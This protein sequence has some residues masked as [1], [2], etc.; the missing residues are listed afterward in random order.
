MPYQLGGGI[1]PSIVAPGSPGAI[2]HGA[3]KSGQAAGAFDFGGSPLLRAALQRR[4][5]RSA[6]NMRRRGVVASKLY[7]LDP[8][9]QQQSIVDTN[10][11]ASGWQADF[12]NQ[13][14]L[15]QYQSSQDWMRGLLG[16]ER[17]YDVQA[18]IAKMQMD[19]QKKAALMQA[20]GQIGGAGAGALAGK[21]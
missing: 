6:S 17:G 7:G 15:G 5:A 2:S 11:E 18:Q 3:L 8:F 21:P 13:A 1:N 16:S 20:L 10:R 14:E 9:Q 19:A 4:A 12:L